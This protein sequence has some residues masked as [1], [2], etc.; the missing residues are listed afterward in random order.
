[1]FHDHCLGNNSFGIAQ[2]VFQKGKFP[3]LKVYVYP[4]TSNPAGK[5]IQRKIVKIQSDRFRFSFTSPD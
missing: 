3:G 4:S 2:Q 1:M 5:Q